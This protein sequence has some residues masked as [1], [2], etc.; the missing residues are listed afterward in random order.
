MVVDVADVL[1]KTVHEKRVKTLARGSFPSN[2][3]QHVSMYRCSKMVVPANS[4]LCNSYTDMAI[5]A[6]FSARHW[7]HAWCFVQERQPSGRVTNL[8]P[9][10]IDRG[11][12]ST[13]ATAFCHL[14]GMH[15]PTTPQHFDETG[16]AGDSSPVR[17]YGKT[18]LILKAKLTNVELRKT[19]P[20]STM[21]MKYA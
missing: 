16:L 14:G 3:S 6:L 2:I 7:W 15:I 17:V 5:V 1:P 20:H 12:T 10:E 11:K 4:R 21:M 18:L 13:R 9:A 8:L 19:E